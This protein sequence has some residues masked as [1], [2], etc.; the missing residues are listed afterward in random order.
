MIIRTKVPKRTSD[1]TIKN[2]KIYF[3]INNKDFKICP[4]KNQQDW[5]TQIIIQCYRDMINR[6]LK[7]GKIINFSFQS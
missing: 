6:Q 4:S 7:L 3:S 1:L 5:V 2:L